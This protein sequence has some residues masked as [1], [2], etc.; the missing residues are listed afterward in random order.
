MRVRPSAL[1]S[2]SPDGILASSCKALLTFEI[3]LFFLQNCSFDVP[4]EL[5]WYSF[6]LTG[7]HE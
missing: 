6:E 5:W 4:E 3:G 1:M 7:V 2:S